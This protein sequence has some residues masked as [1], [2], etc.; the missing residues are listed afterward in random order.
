MY[1]KD[2]NSMKNSLFVKIRKKLLRLNISV[3]NICK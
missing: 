3:Y 2:V 1:G